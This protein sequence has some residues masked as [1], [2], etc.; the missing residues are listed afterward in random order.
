M[1]IWRTFPGQPWGARLALARAQERPLP[2]WLLAWAWPAQG[3]FL[4]GAALFQ[5]LFGKEYK[6]GGRGL[7]WVGYQI[8]LLP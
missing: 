1:G 8:G 6:S 4:Q 2:A 5:G 7:E 3:L